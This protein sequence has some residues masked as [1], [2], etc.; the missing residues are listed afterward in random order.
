M[1]TAVES[2]TIHVSDQDAA[3]AFYTG[4]LGF[5]LERDAPMGEGMRWLA[6]TPPGGGAALILAKGY[7]SWSP[8]KVGSFTGLVLNVEDMGATCDRL[9]E[10]GVRF[11]LEPEQQPWG[12]QAVIADPDGNTFVLRSFE[13][14]EL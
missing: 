2:A 11:D 7:G 6:V 5:R 14:A 13:G 12:M 10:A 4:V 8:E 3:L 9:R 1:I